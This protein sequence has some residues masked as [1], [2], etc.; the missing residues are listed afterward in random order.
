MIT[1]SLT[2][3]LWRGA[4]ERIAQ[5]NLLQAE[6]DMVYRIRDFAQYYRGF[7]VGIASSYFR[8]LQGRDGVL[9]EWNNYKT[10]IDSRAR[11]EMMA[12][13]GRLPEF[14]VGQAEQNEYAAKDNYIRAVQSYEQSIDEFKMQL[15]LPTDSPVAFDPNELVVLRARGIKHPD[16]SPERAV[17]VALAARLDLTTAYDQVSDAGRKVVVAENG[18]APDVDLVLTSSVPTAT[19]QPG[20]FRTAYGTYSAGLDV[21]LPFDR[22]SERNSYRMALIGL[23]QS[24]RGAVLFED[25]VKLGIRA[26]WRRLQEARASYENQ[27]KSLALAE[28]RVESTTMLLEA[29]R[30]STR[31]VLDSHESLRLAQNA[32]TRALVDHMIARLE[33]WRDI[34]ILDVDENGVWQE[35]YDQFFPQDGGEQEP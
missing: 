32:V 4:G 21:G 7:A 8:V 24:K 6:R 30:A 22:K 27:Q 2:K 15:G 23:E 14:E 1:A 16:L 5:E 9:N 34:G 33:F 18:L 19:N 20:A 17:E 26:A 28:R 29:G 35:D 12:D 31:D 13:A 10:L 25:Q 11:T 3:P